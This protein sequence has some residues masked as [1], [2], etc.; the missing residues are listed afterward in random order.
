MKL[1]ELYLANNA[2][3]EDT[4]NPAL[5]QSIRGTNNSSE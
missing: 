4:I 5:L 1:D 3:D 2:L